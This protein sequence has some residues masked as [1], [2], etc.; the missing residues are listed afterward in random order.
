MSD[1]MLEV[2]DEL[3]TQQIKALW[4][5]FGQ[6][7]IGIV[8]LTIL[9]TAVG[10]FWFSHVN[11]KLERDTDRLLAALQKD[12]AD[13]ALLAKLQKE[14]TKPLNAVVG[15]Q[16]AVRLEQANDLKGAIA[17]YQSVIEDSKAQPV[18]RN[19]ATLHRVRLGLVQKENADTLL[20]AI[21]P[22]TRDEAA[23]RASALEMK[24]LI[25]QSQDKNKEANDIFK[26]LATDNAAPNT[27]RQRAQ[28][29]ITYEAGDA[30]K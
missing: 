9:A 21:A 16:R 23:F 24:G 3:R 19:L 26:A 4:A 25:L 14:T 20:T 30:Q 12:N 10:S 11:S 22:L 27:L 8:V 15:L 13:T 2:D 28:S 6:W 29:L 18:L 17:A 5:T 7:I 1:I